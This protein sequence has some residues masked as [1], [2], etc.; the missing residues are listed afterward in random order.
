MSLPRR[1]WSTTSCGGPT[2][3]EKEAEES[4][5]MNFIQ[6]G[7][8]IGGLALAIPVLVHLLSRLQVVR[9]ELGTMRFL[10]EVIQ[11]GSQ[12]RKIR[13]WLL[14][15]LRM[16]T[17]AVLVLL[18]ARPYFPETIRR[19]GDRLRVILIDRSASMGMP[20]QGGR[21]IDDAIAK[22]SEAAGELGVDAKLLWAWFDSQVVPFESTSSRLSAPRSVVGD[23]NYLAALSWARDKVAASP[24][25]I[26]DVVLISDLQQSGLASD[27]F[28]VAALKMPKD[29]P[30]RIVDVGRPAANNLALQSVTFG[31]KRISPQRDVVADVTLFNYGTLPMEEIPMTATASDGRRSVRL[32]KSINVPGGQAQELSFDFGKLEPGVWKVTVQLD[33][34]DDLAIDNR[35]MT[36]FE[37]SQPASV[38][39]IDGG[40]SDAETLPESFYLAAALQQSNREPK[41]LAEKEEAPADDSGLF[42]PR[43]VY[44][45]DGELPVLRPEST[46]LVAVT[47]SGSLSATI[48]ERLERYVAA[49]GK[50]LVFAGAGES[51][52]SG[53]PM[54][55]WNESA[56]S[57][58]EIG[59]SLRSG[60][61]PFRITSVRS[62]H[63]MMLPFGDPQQGDL[64]RLAFEQILPVVPRESTMVLA[65]FEEQRPA[66]TWHRHGEGQV[67][68]FLSSAD[69]SWGDWP[70]S[71][72]YLPVVHQMAAELLSLTGE[73]RIRY[74]SVGDRR[75][76]MSEGISETAATAADLPELSIRTVS[77]NSTSEDSTQEDDALDTAIVFDRPGFEPWG[78][79]L[80]VVNATAKESDPARMPKDQFVDHF[81]ITEADGEAAVEIDAVQGQQKHELWPWLAAAAVILL[82]AEFSLAN[83]TSA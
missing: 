14:L 52:P 32:K 4:F 79:S 60:A 2:G 37:I 49:G 40:S 18:F 51:A 76:G 21:L 34:E 48:V 73:G 80:Y 56:I 66:L 72:L 3:E 64:G 22:A 70:T 46:P 16:A 69:T 25:A 11:D 10:Q 9:V 83:R 58:G 19:D 59:T 47:D 12:R 61:M 67:V 54:S 30:I 57:P 28:E 6:T 24:D 71:P 55:M 5:P 78:Q 43:V 23:T 77:A 65:Q 42:D 75:E 41:V 1:L 38:L 17:I 31:S 81:Q 20:G 74:R 63:S 33:V 62:T 39:V 44:L 35:R 45:F 50:L 36:A 53:S 13:R 8:L 82:T 29:L 15:L 26:A 68:W 7:F 27:A